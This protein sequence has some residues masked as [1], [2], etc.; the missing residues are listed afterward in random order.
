MSFSVNPDQ[1]N[2]LLEPAARSRPA[3]LVGV[4]SLVLLTALTASTLTDPSDPPAQAVDEEWRDLMITSRE[5]VPTAIAKTLNVAGGWPV[6]YGLAIA[7]LAVLAI[8][9]MW[10]PAA[11]VSL[12]ATVTFAIYPL[13]KLAVERERPRWMAVALV[14][15]LAMMWSRTD[16]SV[17]WLSDTV[18]GALLGTGVTLV[19]YWAMAPAAREAR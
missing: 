9:R 18:A 7:T 12:S 10:R 5:D 13:L 6:A 15:T 2:A 4:S 19:L 17:H 11:F 1:A 16:L 8:R 3:L 14:L